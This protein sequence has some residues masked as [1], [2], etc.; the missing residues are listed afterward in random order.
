MLIPRRPKIHIAFLTPE[1]PDLHKPEGGLGNYVRKVSLALI[2]RGHKVTVFVMAPRRRKELDQGI[3]LIF[4]KRI[5][6]H[7]RIHQFK[8]L[9][10]WLD[11]IEQNLTARRIRNAVLALNKQTRIDILQTSNYKIPGLKN[12][13]AEIGRAH[14]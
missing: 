14:V 12:V 8:A 2:Q 5:K 10:G 9:H 7:W 6:F 11:L 4:V 1:Y 3:E 13:D